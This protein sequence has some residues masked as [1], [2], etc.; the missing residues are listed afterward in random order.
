M[1]HS[2]LKLDLTDEVLRCLKDAALEAR[3][4]PED[5]AV[6][7][8]VEALMESHGDTGEG[9][10]MVCEDAAVFEARPSEHDWTEADRRLAEYD[11]TGK[12]VTLEDAMRRFE[13]AVEDKLA[14]RR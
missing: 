10:M 14:A 4:A 7:I 6:R 5:Y 13:Q 8:I 9:G 11:R 3:M 12:F 2:G 1:T